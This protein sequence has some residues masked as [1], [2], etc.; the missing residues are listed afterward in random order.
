MLPGGPGEPPPPSRA[1]NNG[2]IS[3]SF[4]KLIKFSTRASI[5]R[6]TLQN[7]KESVFPGKQ[8]RV[9]TVFPGGNG[10]VVLGEPEVRPALGV[11][12]FALSFK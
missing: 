7:G 6:E 1:V 8:A 2:G 12:P 4:N 9:A 10:G 5:E 3:S 11:A